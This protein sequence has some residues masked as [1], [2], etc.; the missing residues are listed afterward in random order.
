MAVFYKLN[1]L[2]VAKLKTLMRD[3]KTLLNFTHTEVTLCQQIDNNKLVRKFLT[4]DI[5]FQNCAKDG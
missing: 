2:F 4:L 5:I 1:V 3:F